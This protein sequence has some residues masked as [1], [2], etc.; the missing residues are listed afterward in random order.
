MKI[1]IAQLEPVKGDIEKNIAIHTYWI[2]KAIEQRAGL[3]A[4]SELSLTGYEP[5]LAKSLA[6]NQNDKRLDAFQKLSDENDIAIAV[7]LP[8]RERDRLYISMIIFRPA[9]ERT[10]YSKQY[11]Y[12]TETSIFTPGFNPL[13]LEFENDIVAPAICYELSNKEHYEFAAQNKATVYLA[14]VLNSVNGVD[15]DLKKL[16]DIARNYKMITFMANYVGESGGYECAGRSSVWNT[17][18]EIM[19]QLGDKE[20][21]LIIYD[22]R[23]GYSSIIPLI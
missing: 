8:T 3:I 16:S 1:A 12:P 10:T 7:G 20:E 2:K 14:S 17:R 18:G 22:T 9:R 11:L 19:G 23:T 4:F 15:A 6:S 13:V 21:G 5:E